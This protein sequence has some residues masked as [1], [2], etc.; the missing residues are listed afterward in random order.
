MTSI[1]EQLQTALTL[2]ESSEYEAATQFYLNVLR[3]DA[4][5]AE[6]WHRLSVLMLRAG[7]PDT[8]LNCITKAISF[9]GPNAE[10]YC[11]QGLVYHDRNELDQAEANL[12]QAQ[13]LD[14]NNPESLNGLA[15]V[16][17][18]RDRLDEAAELCRQVLADNPDD[19]TA[20]SHLGSVLKQQGRYA[21]ALVEYRTVLVQNP[22]CAETFNN[23]GA[24]FIAL[25]QFE[26]AIRMCNFATEFS[27]G[28]DAARENLALAR[29]CCLQQRIEQFRS[30]VNENDGD[31][32]AWEALAEALHVKG[33]IGPA[34]EAYERALEI[35][36]QQRVARSNLINC[37]QFQCGI[38]ARRMSELY[39]EWDRHHAQPLA[40][41]RPPLDNDPDPD[42]RLRL[43]V[44]SPNLRRHPAAYLTVAG[45]EN[46]DRFQFETFFYSDVRDPDET[47]TRMETIAD[48]WQVVSGTSDADVA[49]AIHS[50]GIDVLLLMGGHQEGSRQ[51][52]VARKPAPVQ[53][54]WTGDPSGQAAVDWLIAD[55]FLIPQEFEEFYAESILRMPHDYATFDPPPLELEID[56]CPCSSN[57]YVTLGSFNQ[58][59]KCHTE[60]LELWAGIMKRLP[61]S[62]LMLIG[63]G[64]TDD[65]ER[66]LATFNAAGIETHR[67]TLR[68]RIARQKLLES[69]NKVD[70]CL[71]THPFSGGVTTLESLWMG[72]P[73]VTM[74]GE[75]FAGRTSLSH[76]SNAGLDDLVAET[77]E[78][79][80]DIA[81]QL[82]RDTTRLSHLRRHL[83]DSLHKSPI[84]DGQQFGQDLSAALRSAWRAWTKQQST[85]D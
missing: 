51:L 61:E 19:M 43:G 67:I 11:Q 6:A 15:A 65:E 35:D 52:V 8:A 55:R 22:E 58:A 37:S 5:N 4:E 84:C 79:Y 10:R 62:R 82:A 42:R 80:A 57:G 7:E 38:T 14:A 85:A 25:G 47:T 29:R 41:E 23:V 3:Q 30:V 9:G 21:E 28:L 71:D 12:R 40:S 20:R 76:L 78:E 24:V 73:V 18:K 72:V 49:E 48:H 39:V 2:D 74:P 83:R 68:D 60:L 34:I 16:L 26:D 75:T 54:A 69:Y 45:F 70:I 36:P 27:P 81:V 32:D 31:G 46:L 33:E 13:Q 50:D 1:A 63:N 66:L 17:L 53:I 64:H 77:P 44:L 59:I 56:P